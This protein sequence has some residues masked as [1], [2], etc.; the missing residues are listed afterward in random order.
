MD[1]TFLPATELAAL[2][3]SGKIGAWNSW[4]TT[5]PAPSG[6][7]PAS[8][9]W[10]SGTSTAPGP[11]PS[12]LDSQPD[13]IRPPVRRPHHRQGKLRRRGPAHHARPSRTEGQPSPSPPSPI[14]RLEAAGAVI[15]GKTNVPV[16]LAD[17]QSYNPVYGTTPTP[18]TPTTRPAD[19]PADQ[20]PPWPP[21]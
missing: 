15:F 12:A 13:K 17:W 2:V 19:P 5:S 21:A 10:S 9:P 20:P 14:R 1:P 18:G 11:A 8:T 7:I 4:T 16:D 6:S 3:R